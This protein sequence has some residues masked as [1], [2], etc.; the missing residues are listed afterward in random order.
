M[1]YLS[2]C[3]FVWM[4]R[5]LVGS[6]TWRLLHPD[7]PDSL[8]FNPLSL[9]GGVSVTLLGAAPIATQDTWGS[10]DETNIAQQEGGRRRKTQTHTVIIMII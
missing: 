9:S 6:A 1:L 2:L 5:C 4:T 3:V 7:F 8:L 10:H